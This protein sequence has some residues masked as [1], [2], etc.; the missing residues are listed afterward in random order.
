MNSVCATRTVIL[1]IQLLDSEGVP[2]PAVLNLT[3]LNSGRF[4]VGLGFG[5]LRDAE[6]LPERMLVGDVTEMSKLCNRDKVQLLIV[7]FVYS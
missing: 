3:N 1:R 5:M 2:H 4:A 6:L 7:Q